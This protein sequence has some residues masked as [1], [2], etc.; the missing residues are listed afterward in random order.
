MAFSEKILIATDLSHA[1][2]VAVDAGALLAQQ[3]AADVVVLYVYD[4]ALLGPMHMMPSAVSVLIDT[5]EESRV[6]EKTA[7][8]ELDR[9]A[10]ARLAGAKSVS[11]V[12][13][14]HKSAA[15]AICEYAKSCNADLIVLGTHG[16]TGLAHMLIGSV[17]ERVVRHA[18]C[19][20]LTLRSKAK[21]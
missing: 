3:F 4:P 5:S 19:P 14:Q 7:N 13:L 21:D 12:V 8:T 15:Q 2:M 20:V 11:V 18:E 17:A 6:F 1:S 10:K 16:R 9:V